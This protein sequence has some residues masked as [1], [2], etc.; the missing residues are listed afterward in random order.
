MPAK[1]LSLAIVPVMAHYVVNSTIGYHHDHRFGGLIVI[2]FP[3][4]FERPIHKYYDFPRYPENHKFKLSNVI[5]A[6]VKSRNC[7]VMVN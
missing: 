2:P 5:Y 6:S 3:Y 7:E 4:I 1:R